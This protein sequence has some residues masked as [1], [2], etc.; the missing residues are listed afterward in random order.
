M[1]AIAPK[2]RPYGWHTKRLKSAESLKEGFEAE[3]TR[4][5]ITAGHGHIAM[6]MLRK[7]PDYASLFRTID[8]MENVIQVIKE[9]AIAAKCAHRH[10]SY[11]DKFEWYPQRDAIRWRRDAG[12]GGKT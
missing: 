9:D 6:D 11:G 3:M 2:D 4:V 8:S 7:N 5:V 10:G 1:E 12:L